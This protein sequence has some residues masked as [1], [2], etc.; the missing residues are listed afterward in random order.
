VRLRRAAELPEILEFLLE[1]PERCPAGRKAD[2]EHPPI[3]HPD[4]RGIVEL[5]CLE[6]VGDAGDTMSESRVFAQDLPNSG[7]V[8]LAELPSTA[9]EGWRLVV[10]AVRWG[11]GKVADHLRGSALA[12]LALSAFG[13]DAV[14]PGLGSSAGACGHHRAA[15]PAG[16][17][18]AGIGWAKLPG[19]CA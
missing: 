9:S 6:I 10:V 1:A 11:F 2:D 18:A 15:V 17:G 19:G 14:G 12:D 8:S 5:P 4:P 7:D 3:A 16:V 13:G